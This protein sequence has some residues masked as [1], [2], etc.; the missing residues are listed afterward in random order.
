MSNYA[1]VVKINPPLTREAFLPLV[2]AAVL[3]VLDS[4]WKVEWTPHAMDGP[5][6][7]VLVP[8]TSKCVDDYWGTA[9]EGN[10]PEDVNFVLALKN[11]RTIAF[12]HHPTMMFA[13]WAQG[14][15]E[16]ELS[17]RLQAPLYYDA[18]PTTYEPGHREYRRGKTLREY[19]LRN[20]DGK[21]EDAKH[22]QLLA[23]HMRGTPAGFDT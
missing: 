4:R 14:C 3:A 5:T 12:R 18:G 11:K 22:E 7:V 21:V 20:F 9:N 17:E 13:R 16:E 23:M 10:K 2:E 8:G 19:L 15:L 1:Y 6:L